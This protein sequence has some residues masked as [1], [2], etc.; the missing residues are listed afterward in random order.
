MDNKIKCV[1]QRPGQV[2]EVIEVNARNPYLDFRRIFGGDCAEIIQLNYDFDIIADYERVSKSL[3]PN[4]SFNGK[5]IHGTAIVVADHNGEGFNSMTTAE[6]Q[7]VR[8]WLLKHT[9]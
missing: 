4:I 1:I 9:I 7:A 3:K 6:I 2:S 8:A 5:T